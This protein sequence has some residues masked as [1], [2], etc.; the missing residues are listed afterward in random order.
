MEVV[1]VDYGERFVDGAVGDQYCVGCAPEFGSACRHLEPRRKS[2]EFLKDIFD[3]NA[4]FKARADHLPE[5]LLNVL[6]DTNT[7]LPN[8]ARR[9]S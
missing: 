5:R 9:A 6:A 3:R 7:S 8:P 4:L 1:S 2:V